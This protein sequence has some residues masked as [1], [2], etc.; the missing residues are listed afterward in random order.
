MARRRRKSSSGALLYDT[1]SA[2]NRLPWQGSEN[3][4]TSN[5]RDF[6]PELAATNGRSNRHYLQLNLQSLP[7]TCNHPP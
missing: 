6:R 2:A 3:A 7:P 5:Q 4:Q 1:A